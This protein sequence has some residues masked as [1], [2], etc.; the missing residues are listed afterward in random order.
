MAGDT[1][2]QALE[3]L[4]YMPDRDALKNGNVIAGQNYYDIYFTGGSITGVAISG[5]T[6]PLPIADGG[7]GQTTANAALNALLPTQTGNAGKALK[8]DGTNTSWS[9]DTDTGITQLT[10]DVTAGPG[11]GSQ[12]ATLATVNS[13]VGAFGSSTSIPSI[14]VNGKG[15]ITAASGNAVVAPAG[16]LTGATLASGV[17]ASSLTSF[18]TSPTL[19]TPNI[20]AATGT[21]LNLSGLTV[22]SAVATDGSKNLV[23]VTN[24]GSGNNVLATSPSIT[25]PTIVTSMTL[26]AGSLTGAAVQA[27][28]ETATS[29]TTFV[30]PGVA[31]F[32]P[33][34]AKAWAF[35]I[36]SAGT[37][38]L[39]ANLGVSSLTDNGT[40][41]LTINLTTAFSSAN[42]AP[43]LTGGLNIGS[44]AYLFASLGGITASTV[45]V[46]FVNYA[47]GA[48]NDTQF[49]SFV[50]F[51]DL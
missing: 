19:V 12:A 45:R 22:S 36:Y 34:A 4:T 40:G 17:T 47:T 23:S 16:T 10:G 20:G 1:T 48:A 41:D 39:Q 2:Y 5:L 43:I 51:G 6:A 13:N 46:F 11:S 31:K 7:T 14:T 15:L 28:M 50:G 32:A 26:P 38:T 18:G 33:S 49:F 8:T 27:D 21:S 24:T 37:P 42:W 29:L 3:R 9:T 44:T 25:T 30:N 35:G